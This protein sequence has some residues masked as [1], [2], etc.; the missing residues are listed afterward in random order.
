MALS[1]EGLINSYVD[2]EKAK[3]SARLGATSQQQAA[4]LGAVNA[5]SNPQAKAGSLS[6]AGGL[7]PAVKIG[8]AVAVVTVLA[9]A[10]W[11]IKK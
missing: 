9:L 7:S 8:G 11:M 5:T 4:G 6:F 3:I 10:F 1:I 2:L